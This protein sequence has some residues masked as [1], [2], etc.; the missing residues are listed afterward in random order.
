MEEKL[1]FPKCNLCNCLAEGDEITIGLS[2]GYTI[3]GTVAK[4]L[5]DCQV[6]RLRVGAFIFVPF[7][8]PTED[9]LEA[10]VPL[11]VCCDAIEF[12]TKESLFTPPPPSIIGAE[13]KESKLNLWKKNSKSRSNSSDYSP[14]CNLCDCLSKGDELGLGLAGGTVAFGTVQKILCD[15]TVLRLGNDSEI[16]P[17]GGPFL[18]PE[19]PIFICCSDIQWL[20]R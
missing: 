2:G 3:I 17:P 18:F 14:Q 11:F 12:L 6:L 13:T 5:C 7:V 9:F 8:D 15:C 20:G 19:Q 16:D 1:S 4:I 10:P